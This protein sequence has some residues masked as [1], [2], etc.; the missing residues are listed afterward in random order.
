[1]KYL[2]PCLLVLF[3]LSVANAQITCSFKGSVSG[4]TY[5]FTKLTNNAQD[6]VV[7]VPQGGNV[8][9][10]YSI[11]FNLCRSIISTACSD[12]GTDVAGCQQWP[13]PQNTYHEAIGKASGLQ[14]AEQSFSGAKDGY[15][16]LVS[17]T[18]MVNQL[19]IQML[20]AESE[21]QPA[22][23]EKQG[24][25][26]FFLTWSTPKA[27]PVGAGPNNGGGSSKKGLSVGSVMLIVLLVVTVVY[28]VGGILFQ[29]FRNHASG[30]DLIPNRQF[31]SELPLLVRDGFKFVIGK[32]RGGGSSSYQSV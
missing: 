17:F 21:G 25:N 18:G 9:I 4:K 28:F 2:A 24:S 10:A 7:Q 3:C 32:I 14:F 1:M 16:G 26:Q 30:G 12:K 13:T 20:C 22:F 5:D 15:G 29:K 27:C 19:N 31:W 8:P 23:K 11:T 6:Y